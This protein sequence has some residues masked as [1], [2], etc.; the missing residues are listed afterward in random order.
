MTW[1][2]SEDEAFSSPHY[3]GGC[4]W[5]INLFEREQ[6][7]LGIFLM[8]ALNLG[9]SQSANDKAKPQLLSF[10]LRVGALPHHF[11]MHAKVKLGLKPFGS[12]LCEPPL[13]LMELTPHFLTRFCSRWFRA[14]VEF[15]ISMSG[16]GCS[17]HAG[18]RARSYFYPETGDGR[19]QAKVEYDGKAV[20]WADF[21]ADNSPWLVNGTARVRFNLA[22]P[23]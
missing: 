8:P 15:G 22:A 23:A 2:A 4:F 9:F 19:G 13:H 3:W 16:T 14:Q 12:R 5:R 20:T 11:Q 6:G 10:A 7:G 1:P 18:G 21:W 17:W